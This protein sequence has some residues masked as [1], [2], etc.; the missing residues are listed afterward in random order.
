MVGEYMSDISGSHQLELI[1]DR[2]PYAIVSTQ[3]ISQMIDPSMIHRCV[4]T[5]LF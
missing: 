5:R 4:T 2:V 1:I 3:K